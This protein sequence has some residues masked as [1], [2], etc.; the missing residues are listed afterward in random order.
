MADPWAGDDAC[1][2]ASERTLSIHSVH[3]RRRELFYWAALLLIFAGGSAAGDLTAERLALG[4]GPS[5]L[6]FGAMIGAV[7]LARYSFRANAILSFWLV[8]VLTRPFGAFLGDLL[9]QAPADG[10]PGLGTVVTTGLF[11]AAI[12]SLVAFLTLSGRRTVPG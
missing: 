6:L 9:Q 3:T 12:T 2:Y 11:L 8:Y 1:R 4:Y 7:A 5:T 10:G